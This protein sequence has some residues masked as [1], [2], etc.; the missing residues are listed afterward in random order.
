MGEAM[1]SQEVE[2]LIRDAG[3]DPVNYQT[4]VQKMLSKAT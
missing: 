1:S 3:G 2:E 4:F